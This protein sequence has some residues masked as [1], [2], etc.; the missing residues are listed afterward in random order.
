MRRVSF[1]D[2]WSVRPK[3]SAFL[4]RGGRMPSWTPV[5][6]PHD[7]MI[8][9]TRAPSEG[10]GNAY[11]PGGSWDYQK[12]FVVPAE[13]RGK[14]MFVEFEGVY[15]DATVSVNGAFAA[16]HP[17]GYTGFA[18]AIDHLVRHGEENEIRVEVQAQEDARWYS[19]AGIYRNVKLVV[20]E[21]VHLVLD[22][23]FVTTPSI[24]DDLAVVQVEAVVENDGTVTLPTSITTEILDDHGVVV[25][26]EV[27][28]VT[29]FPRRAATVRQRLGVP[30]PRRWS[31]DTP[32]L[33]TCRM[34]IRDLDGAEVDADTTTFGIRSLDVDAVRGLRINGEIV[35]LRG[36]CIHHD[37]GVIGAAT[38]ERADERRIEL[39]KTAGFNA[40]RSAHHPASKALLG[41]VRPARRAR[42]GRGLRH[43]DA[44][45]DAQRLP[46]R[47]HGV[48]GDRRRRHGPQGPQP[49]ERGPVLDRKRDPRHG[50]SDRRRARPTAH[51]PDPRCP[52]TRASSPTA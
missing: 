7:V 5:V 40:I 45:E 21:P 13:D 48:V 29:S 33:Y 32:T 6:L 31:P 43:V 25:A 19:G 4:E 1:N 47:V 27:T 11:F 8:G 38:V 24:D 51:R 35:N 15:R 14:R 3:V 2:G 18:V 39:L 52:T 23:L 41:R 37:N 36:A 17:Y 46:P 28:P 12:R 10:P 30:E 42:H 9:S 49:P 26:S 44:T 34:V 22:S 20:G 50:R 16:H